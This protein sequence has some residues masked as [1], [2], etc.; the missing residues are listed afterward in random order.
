MA[1]F[2]R[3]SFLRTAGG[4]A[5]CGMAAPTAALAGMRPVYG[6]GD[7]PKNRWRTRVETHESPAENHLVSEPVPQ[8]VA[9]SDYEHLDDRE[10]RLFIR[11]K[12]TGEVF[13][14][15]FRKGP[16]VYQDSLEQIDR[17]LRDWRRDEVIEI[18]RSLIELLATV[19]H[20]I[21]Y[22][23]PIMIRS[24]YRS[25]QT[26]NMLRRKQR[27]VAKNSYH[28]KGMA[29][30]ITMDH[31]SMNTLRKLGRKM[32]AGGVGYYP[33]S[34]FVHLDTGPVRAWRA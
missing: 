28:I 17:L 6:S 23:E 9:V 16:L 5:A 14:D 1:N 10:Q 13:N 7:A 27:G 33:R 11:V 2:S 4:A 15:V 12:R 8:H 25:V 20:E 3:R 21:G 32:K 29:A 22:A 30:D 18:D 19:Q 24:G 34:G 31:V 26:N